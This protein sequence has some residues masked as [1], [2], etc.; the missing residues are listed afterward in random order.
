MNELV[1]SSLRI[2]EP[3]I[4]FVFDPLDEAA[5]EAVE[6]LN[7][8]AQ[9]ATVRSDVLR[10]L[11]VGGAITEEDAEMLVPVLAEW[12]TELGIEE[13][14]VAPTKLITIAVPGAPSTYLALVS[15]IGEADVDEDEDGEYED[16]DGE[17]EDEDDG[18]KW[19]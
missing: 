6:V 14:V 13:F 17:Y 10:E 3:G 2:T 4:H 11:S 8:H 9:Q 7:S 15:V 18:E 5:L 19:V 16:E 12:Q 1:V